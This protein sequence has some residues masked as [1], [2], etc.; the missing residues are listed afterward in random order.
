VGVQGA[1]VGTAAKQTS[2]IPRSGTA[3]TATEAQNGQL[4]V[5]VMLHDHGVYVVHNSPWTGLAILK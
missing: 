2:N 3:K 1:D 4:M 5:G